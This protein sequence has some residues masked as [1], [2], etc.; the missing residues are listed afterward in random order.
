MISYKS[1]KRTNLVPSPTED[2][3]S[4]KFFLQ[5]QFFKTCF[6]LGIIL[7]V[8]QTFHTVNEREVFTLHQ[9]S[10]KNATRI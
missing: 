5:I 1:N 3:I 6:P 2:T 4:N 8:D 9:K 7:V 10:N